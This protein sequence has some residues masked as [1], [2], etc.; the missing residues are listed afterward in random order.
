MHSSKK[1]HII[2][3]KRII[4]V[5]LFYFFGLNIFGDV[6]IPTSFT[7]I[8]TH[9]GLSSNRINTIFKD[10]RGFIWLGTRSGVNRFDG[11][12]VKKYKQ[13]GDEEI[14]CFEETDEI[15]IWIG[16]EKGLKR[17][18]R[19]INQAETISL[20]TN[21]VSVRDIHKISN[22]QLLIASNRGL[23]FYNDGKIE[24]F[25]FENALSNTNRLI[26][27]VSPGQSEFL[28]RFQIRIVLFQSE[29]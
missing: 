23:F 2:L 8:S 13:I 1:Y 9:D 12:N 27:I 17:L 19:K 15:Y 14:F 24:H 10:E 16:S 26:E 4:F 28:D 22:N 3:S 11:N 6:Q 21:D 29:R 20:T 5:L 18:N 25:I 7:T